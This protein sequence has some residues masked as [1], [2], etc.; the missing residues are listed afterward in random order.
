MSCGGLAQG[1]GVRRTG[2][3]TTPEAST[4]LIYELLLKIFELIHKF[5]FILLFS[6]Y[7]VIQ[8]RGMVISTQKLS[9]A[10][11]QVTPEKFS[12]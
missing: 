7:C 8:M 10:T 2:F 9:R 11:Q 3:V 6:E 5:G 1:C 4:V 12:A